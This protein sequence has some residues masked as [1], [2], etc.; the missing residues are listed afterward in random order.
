MKTKKDRQIDRQIDMKTKKDRQI[1]MNRV[2]QTDD[3]QIVRY[4]MTENANSRDIDEQI[5]IDFI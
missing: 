4:E 1:D 5:G 3:I 2:R